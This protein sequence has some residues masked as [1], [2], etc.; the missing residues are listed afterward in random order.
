MN[1]LNLQQ[2]AEEFVNFLFKH[3][4]LHGV[5]PKTF[6]NRNDLSESE[7]SNLLNHVSEKMLSKGYDFEAFIQNAKYADMRITKL[8]SNIE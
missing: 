3:Q 8:E 2:E 1:N 5:F 7:L 4:N 6:E